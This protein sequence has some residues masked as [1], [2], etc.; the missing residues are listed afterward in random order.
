MT[1]LKLIVGLGNIGTEYA[2]TRHNAGFWFVDELAYRHKAQFKAEKKF[3]CEIAKVVIKH[4]EIRLIKPTTFMNLSGQAVAA[5]AHFYRVHPDEI[6]VVHDELDLPTGSLKLKQGGGNNGHNG[7]KDI[8][9]RLGTPNF[10][11]LRLGIEHP[12]DKNQVV[13]Y[14]LK[15]PTLEQQVK[16]DESILNALDEIETIV[17]GDFQTAMNRLHSK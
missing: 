2:A 9:A 13:S 16:I 10:W 12:G 6:L 7:L 4:R 3:F 11:R 1:P 17:A 15:K 5:V 8:Q 14:V